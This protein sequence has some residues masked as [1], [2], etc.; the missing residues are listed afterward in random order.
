MDFDALRATTLPGLLLERARRRPARVAFRAKEL[1]VWRETTWRE[2]ADPVAAV[3]LGL[4]GECA[5]ARGERGAWA[6][7]GPG[8]R[9]A[10]PA[11]IIYTSGTTGKP[12]GA[13]Y[14]H[15]AHAAGCANI[16]A[17]YAELTDGEHR[18]VAMLPL[19]HTMGRDLTI[20]MPLLA[21]V[22]PHYPE[23]MEAFAEALFE[24]QPTF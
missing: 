2:L 16:L 12:K 22:V 11:V 15:G 3:A 4:A 7:W 19:C 10:A 14:R 17:H 24:V 13:W 1:G 21:D 8:V 9:P 20:T 23:S 6:G 5:V 18:I